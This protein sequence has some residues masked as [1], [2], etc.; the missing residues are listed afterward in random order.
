MLINL[1][2]EG[3]I[4]KKYIPIVLLC[5]TLILSACTQ[6]EEDTQEYSGIIVDGKVMGYEYTVT[7]EENSFSWKVGYKGDITTI[8]ESID[9]QDE[10]QNFMM[11]VSD[12]KLILSKLIISLSYFIIVAVI[13]FFLYKKNRKTLKDVAIVV[14]LASIIALYIAIDASFDLSIALQDIKLHYLRLT[15]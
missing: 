12:S 11:A 15:N 10:L 2:K 4:I 7:K 1:I 3:I 14:V 13:S 9:N 5:F 8:E 6:R